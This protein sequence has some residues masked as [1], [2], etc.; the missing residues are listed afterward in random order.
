M[1]GAV[2]ISYPH[3]GLRVYVTPVFGA[4]TFT[5]TTLSRTAFVITEQDIIEDTL[6][7]PFC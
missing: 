1:G 6:V 2:G 7:T 5:M 4:T 3:G